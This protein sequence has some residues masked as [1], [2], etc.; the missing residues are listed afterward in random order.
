VSVLA[1]A[2]MAVA[3]GLG[4]L[5]RYGM[6]L[7]F[8]RRMLGPAPAAILLVNLS[9]AL[10]IGVLAGAGLDG[11]ARAIAATGF[12]GGYTTFSTWM[13]QSDELA[14]LNGP[15]WAAANL[16]GSL[17]LGFGAVAL[18]VAVG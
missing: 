8:E 11:D 9:G 10:A 13:V 16:L 12:L 15:R 5:G 2:A 14:R 18:G 17:L 6:V 4:A 1:W 7:V 3:G